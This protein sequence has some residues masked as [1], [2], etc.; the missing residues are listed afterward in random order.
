[1]RVVLVN[2]PRQSIV[3]E[4]GVGHQQPLG[5]LMIGGPLADA[6]HDVRLIDAERLHLAPEQIAR[7]VTAWN[8]EAVIISHVAST[9]GHPACLAALEAIKAADP[10]V[11]TI[12]GGVF[13]TYHDRDILAQHPAVDIIIRG[14][15]EVTARD[16]IDTLSA[17][18]T[19]G[20]QDLSG[21]RGISWRRCGEAAVNPARPPLADLDQCRI[22]WELVDDWD[23]YQA[24][25][26]GRAAVVQFS[27]G[28]PHTCTYCG[29]WMFWKH[30]RYRDPV[31]FADEVEWLH[32]EHGVRF[33]WLADEN[34]TTLQEVWREALNE[35]SRRNLP[36]GFCASIRAQDIVRDAA[37]LDRYRAAGFVYV[38]MGVETVTDTALA[39]I[40]KGST[41]DDAYEAVRLLRRHGIMSIVDY[42]FGI[43][44]ETP[45]TIWR[46]LRGLQRY[47]SDF[48]NALY[49]TP[50]EWT[51]LG[52]QLRGQKVVTSN[53]ANWDY[54]HQVL[55]V[56]RLNPAL[57]FAG[58]KLV[59][60]AYHL[61]PRRLWRVL[62]A[63]D[64]RLR[65][66][67][68]FSYLRT[69]AVYFREIAEFF[70]HSGRA[71]SHNQQRQ[72]SQVT[73]HREYPH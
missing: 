27:R 16:L 19:P 71:P 5:L 24:F 49:L 25:G 20:H 7:R 4:Y 46:G 29:Q 65:A 12:Y 40:R 51:P 14:E 56:P 44:Q 31:R 1:M 26:M 48:V 11:I 54:R 61:H 28:C 45:A 43:E 47:D 53:Y 17:A 52:H 15:G 41:V 2:G 55:A 30:W 10:A 34:P 32:R 21:V 35:I 59:E 38:L 3:C 42:L 22:G 8:A 57:L 64:R 73:V 66:Q 9:A 60:A 23:G 50:H 68:R 18:D 13:P 67:L 58:V 72:V 63:P 36:I 37:F 70:G 39:R 69:A 62:A 33:F 6:G